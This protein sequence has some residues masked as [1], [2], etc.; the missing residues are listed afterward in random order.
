MRQ[1]YVVNFPSSIHGKLQADRDTVHKDG[2]P[3]DLGLAQTDSLKPSFPA[4]F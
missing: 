2:I 4:A 1:T 3:A